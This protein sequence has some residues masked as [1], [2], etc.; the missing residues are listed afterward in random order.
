MTLTSM[1]PLSMQS[2]SS[3]GL[4]QSSKRPASD[5]LFAPGRVVKKS[6]NEKLGT[7]MIIPPLPPIQGDAALAIFVHRSLSPSKPNAS[8]GDGERLA[9]LGEQVL[10]MVV[11]EIHFERRPMLEVNSLIVCA[12]V[13][14]N[15]LGIHVDCRRQSWPTR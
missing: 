12:G 7:K 3:Q 13:D 2:N 5:L 8:F 6:R 1:P 10:R 14:P 15:F 4:P 9:F 11:A